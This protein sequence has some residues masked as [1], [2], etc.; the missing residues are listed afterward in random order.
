M[1]ETRNLEKFTD[2]FIKERKDECPQ[3]TTE[4]IRQLVSNVLE[5]VMIKKPDGT[6]EEWVRELMQPTIDILEGIRSN[7]PVPGYNVLLNVGNI[8]AG[9]YAGYMDSTKERPMVIGAEFDIASM[10]K[11]PTQTLS[12]ILID[13]NAFNLNH[14][15]KELDP[16]FIN[17]QDLTVDDI[18]RFAVSFRTPG[19]I[20]GAET[21]EE[22]LDRLY[23]EEVYNIGYYN[24]NDMGMMTMKEVMEYIT[25]MPYEKLVNELIVKPLGLKNTHLVVP[26]NKIA[27][28]TGSP[29]WQIGAIN[30]G[31][32]NALKEGFGGQA[33]IWMSPQDWIIYMN[34]ITKGEL[35]SDKAIARTY[36]SGRLA[37][38][39]GEPWDFRSL[40]GNY[41]TSDVSTDTSFTDVLVPKTGSSAQG[42]TRCF[43][44]RFPDGAAFAGL[45]PSSISKAEA[46]KIQE[47]NGLSG[48]VKD[49]NIITSGSVD[50]PHTSRFTTCIDS[51]NWMPVGRTQKPIV[52]SLAELRIKLLYLQEFMNEYNYANEKDLDVK[53]YTKV[54]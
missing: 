17:V 9:M 42:S 46:L 38:A 18:K 8:D 45:N 36:T 10:T 16:R 23:R 41:Y 49:I 33:G 53:V 20:D 5:L 29:N 27:L 22:A 31:N 6:P 14:K 7:Y 35:I 26:E 25:N 40:E 32:A 43:G 30:D 39:K 37:D 44:L 51:R 1:E 28:L 3:A 54:A 34:A 24:Y 48:K 12:D 21:S 52:R 19:R 2:D 47:A 50:G 11:S 13:N 15:I 4:E